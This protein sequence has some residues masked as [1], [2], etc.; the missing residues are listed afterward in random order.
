M[1]LLV[2]GDPTAKAEH[3]TLD[4]EVSCLESYLEA[5]P[6]LCVLG[7]LNRV[8]PKFLDTLGIYSFY[9]PYLQT[10]LTMTFFLRSGPCFILPR[11]GLFGGILAW[12]FYAIQVLNVIS[13]NIKFVEAQFNGESY[14]VNVVVNAILGLLLVIVSM[15]SLSG[16][17]KTKL[18]LVLKFPPILIL[19]IFGFIT[20]GRSP[21][22][23]KFVFTERNIESLK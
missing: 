3:E 18:S 9:R 20:F 22:G 7:Y 2:K 4:R 11:Q 23:K 17:W 12:R 14:I 13:F 6:S 8:K 10:C 16:H 19:P 5:L 21:I 1:L 15:H